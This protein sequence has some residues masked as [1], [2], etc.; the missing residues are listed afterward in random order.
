MAVKASPV[1]GRNAPKTLQSS[2]AATSRAVWPWL[3]ERTIFRPPHLPGGH[4][5]AGDRLLEDPVL[6][7]IEHLDPDERSHGVV[8]TSWALVP[9]IMHRT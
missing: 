2:L 1:A 7:G 6:V 8:G 3:D 5:A 4:L 9:T